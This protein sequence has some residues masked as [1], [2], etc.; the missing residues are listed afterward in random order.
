MTRVSDIIR[1]WN[2]SAAYR[3]RMMRRHD[4]LHESMYPYIEHALRVRAPQSFERYKERI[5]FLPVYGQIARSFADDPYAAGVSRTYTI[6]NTA[7]PVSEL[8]SRYMYGVTL[9]DDR[10]ERRWHSLIGALSLTLWSKRSALLLFDPTSNGVNVR[11]IQPHAAVVVG[12]TTT[13]DLF[14]RLENATAV[15][16]ALAD[17]RLRV[18]TRTEILVTQLDGAVITR[19]AN[20]LAETAFPFPF[21]R[22]FGELPS[23]GAYAPET[24]EALATAAL[25]AAYMETEIQVASEML[26]PTPIIHGYGTVDDKVQIGPFGAVK[27]DKASEQG[28]SFA[29]P[30]PGAAAEKR[31]QL[32]AFLQRLERVYLQPPGALSASGDAAMSG[33]ARRIATRALLAARNRW[34]TEVIAIVDA[35]ALIA[36]SDFASLWHGAPSLESVNVIPARQALYLDPTE[37]ALIEADQI[38]RG[39]LSPV[40]VIMRREGVDRDTAI[41]ILQ[42]N[43]AENATASSGLLDALR[44]R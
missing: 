14:S 43:R 22:L 19:E 20:P 36:L 24:G 31:A 44:R 18:W 25:N 33:V 3:D 26:D 13:A 42:R 5:T 10:A 4:F 37:I 34:T 39:I 9:P 40:D 38:D 27:S 23:E 30:D 28:L 17:K 7:L 21:I 2:E 6:G 11:L 35:A 41:G 8:L 1:A 12:D 29:G 32:G 16:V 15:I